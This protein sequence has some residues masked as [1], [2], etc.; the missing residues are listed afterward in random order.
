MP[1][2][3][4][5]WKLWFSRAAAARRAAPLRQPAPTKSPAHVAPSPPLQATRPC[6]LRRSELPLP[7]PPRSPPRAQGFDAF[8]GKLKVVQFEN[9]YGLKRTEANL[10]KVFGNAAAAA[11]ARAWPAAFPLPA[12][13]SALHAWPRPPLTARH[14]S[15]EPHR[16]LGRRPWTSTT[17]TR[18]GRCSPRTPAPQLRA[19]PSACAPRRTHRSRSSPSLAQEPPAPPPPRTP[20]SP[21]TAGKG[22]RFRE[23]L[24]TP[25][26]PGGAAEELQLGALER[27]YVLRA[28]GVDV[29][30]NTREGLVDAAQQIDIRALGVTPQK[31]IMANTE[32][33]FVFLTP[34]PEN[35]QQVAQFD[36]ETE[37][38][39]HAWKPAKDGV[40]QQL[41]DIVTRS[42]G[43]QLT[44][45]KT[46]MSV[47]GMQLM[48]WD[49]RTAAGGQAASSSLASPTVMARTPLLPSSLLYVARCLQG[50]SR[51]AAR[52][53][54]LTRP[55]RS[56]QTYAGGTNNSTNFNFTCVATTG[57][58]HVAVANNTGEVRCF[59]DKTLT[60]VRKPPPGKMEMR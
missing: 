23:S 46:F 4:R 14:I 59:T 31:A 20:G 39:I 38:V 3:R 42:K 60:R 40:D 1:E 32:R 48:Y 53:A 8:E 29:F 34:Q 45:D 33:Q 27:S 5:D 12:R 26:R 50:R 6:T 44:D 11:W 51:L 35:R 30:K 54:A 49:M 10:K 15:H 56:P 19:A 7:S 25:A 17:W 2:F 16:S 36:I 9:A 41:V 24:A 55:F 52:L 47:S 21:A 57:A 28:D 18:R 58:G 37:K 43:A 22:L 13:L